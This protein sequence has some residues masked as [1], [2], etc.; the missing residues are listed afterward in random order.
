MNAASANNDQ[1]SSADSARNSGGAQNRAAI[2]SIDLQSAGFTDVKLIVETFVVPA[3][4][5]MASGRHDGRPFWYVR[6]RGDD[7]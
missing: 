3:R 5:A 2:K 4:S 6:V 7:T 1:K